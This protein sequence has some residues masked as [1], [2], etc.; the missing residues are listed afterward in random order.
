MCAYCSYA[1]LVDEGLGSVVTA[2]P[3]AIHNI[4][5]G[6]GSEPR[7]NG[8][9]MLQKGAARELQTVLEHSGTLEAGG[10]LTD[11][12]WDERPTHCRSD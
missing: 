11:L 9:P 12:A 1:Q 5:T 3:G 10:D 7:S 6:R 4:W 8:R 2:N